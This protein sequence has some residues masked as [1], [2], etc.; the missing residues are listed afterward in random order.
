MTQK[1]TIWIFTA[2]K[3]SDIM[4]F[5]LF[6]MGLKVGKRSFKMLNTNW[7][8]WEQSAVEDKLPYV[9]WSKEEGITLR[10]EFRNSFTGL[11]SRSS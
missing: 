5:Y 9:G 11:L 8:F 7:L 6:Y 4:W 2:V 3:A 1:T 10:N